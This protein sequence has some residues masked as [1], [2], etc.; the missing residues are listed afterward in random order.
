MGGG[1]GGAH[2]AS[3]LEQQLSVG[4]DVPS[5]K[6]VNLTPAEELWNAAP[7]ETPTRADVQDFW[8]WGGRPRWGDLSLTEECSV[9]REVEFIVCIMCG[10]PVWKSNN[11]FFGEYLAWCIHCRHQ[12]YLKY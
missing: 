8:G 9:L 4:M 1:A 11:F 3:C 5:K 7:G 10:I 12:N 6:Q 2:G